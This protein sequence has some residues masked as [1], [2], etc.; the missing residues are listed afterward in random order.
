MTWRVSLA[1]MTARDRTFRQEITGRRTAA[2]GDGPR[3]CTT[4]SRID[5]LPNQFALAESNPFD[6][7]AEIAAASF[8]T[9]CNS[10]EET[11][12][13]ALLR[14]QTPDIG[15]IDDSKF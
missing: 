3:A 4:R 10:D 11:L 9:S 7:T 14:R 6:E 1:R 2:G 8:K 15:P 12:K 13:C 5:V